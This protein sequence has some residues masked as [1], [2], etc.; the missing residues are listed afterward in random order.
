MELMKAIECM[1]YGSPDVLQ[2]KEVEKPTPK[3]NEVLI[4]IYATTVSS[5]DAR[6]RS[7][8]F[9]PMVKPLIRI[10]KGFRGPRD[11]VLGSDL[12][13]EIE[14]VGKDV[15]RFKNG[16]QIFGSTGMNL[17]T[18]VEYICLSEDEVLAIKPANITYEEA[19]AIPF[20]GNTALHYLKE[21]N[22]QSATKA[23][24]YGAS[25]STGTFAVQIAKS[26]G[27]EVTGVCSTSNMELVKS[28][29]ADKV[30]D[31]T[32]E[33]FTKSGETYDV[34][35]DAVG[36]ISKSNCKKALTQN[37]RY[38]TVASFKVAIQKIDNLI[39]LKELVKE[40]KLKP[41]IDRSYP[42]EQIVEAHRY[43]DKGHKKGNVVITV[44]HNGKT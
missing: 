16:D 28:L 4:R 22:I 33:D 26:F 14:S 2:L 30:I 11:N 34:I 38:V 40:G 7:L 20:G 9:P 44:A 3:D 42:F 29:G 17:G 24:I 15:T 10:T 18:N 1:K 19:A 12:A 37:G 36:K 43:V 41:V 27:A 13:G 31:Y 25:G 32:Q 23:L 21:G 5:G 8:N 39:F 35:F 6:N